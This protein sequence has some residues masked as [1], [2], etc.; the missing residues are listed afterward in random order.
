MNKLKELFTDKKTRYGGYSVFIILALIV[1]LVLFNIV[2]QSLDIQFDFTTERLFSVSDQTKKVLENVDEEL[3][4]YGMFNKGKEPEVITGILNDYTRLSKHV[5]I[6]YVDPDYDPVFMS[7]FT[8]DGETIPLNSLVVDHKGRF[9]VIRSNEMGTN[10]ANFSSVNIEQK[11]TN[12]IVFLSRGYNP[13]IYEIAGHGESALGQNGYG[14]HQELINNN[15]ILKQ[16]NLMTAPSIPAD[17]A[18]I[19]L[20][21]GQRDISAEEVEMISDWVLDGG[22]L[23]MLFEYR[24]YDYPNFYALAQK[25]GFQVENVVIYEQDTTRMTPLGGERKKNL[26]IPFQQNHPI[27]R[28]T[29]E[30]DMPLV[31]SNSVAIF[32]AEQRSRT[33]S[34]EPLLMTSRLA[35]AKKAVATEDGR[36]MEITP[37]GME[38]GPFNLA[39]A[40]TYYPRDTDEE[41]GYAVITGS[42]TFLA[43]QIRSQIPGNQDFFLNVLS[44]LNQ[45]EETISIRPKIILNE[46]MEIPNL[47]L[48]YLYTGI[49]ILIIPLSFLVVGLVIWLRRRHK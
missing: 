1:G 37:E 39:V 3:I 15:Y 45:E 5:S 47:F 7:R 31:F 8:A 46:R 10:Q 42:A 21:P 35:T 2:V 30:A 43:P 6:E 44:W 23:F 17:C 24:G 18:V 22:K 14:L 48:I 4:I 32:E 33:I 20:T 13:V 11:I 41:T 9:Q 36:V 29:I 26:P 27:L 38:R 12:A 34:I 25:L 40:A 28:P 19:V 16:L 49:I